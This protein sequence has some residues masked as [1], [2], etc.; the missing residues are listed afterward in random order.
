MKIKWY[1]STLVIILA[2]VGICS[3]QISSPNQEILIKYDIYEVS[4]EQSKKAIDVI[5]QQLSEFGVEDFNVRESE[6]GE[7]RISYRS[8]TAVESIK[9][10]L[11]GKDLG[12]D[13]ISTHPNRSSDKTPTKEPHKNFNLD[14][15]EL[16]KSSDTNSTGKFAWII[17]Q[18]YDRYLNSNFYPAFNFTE[19]LEPSS[20]NSSGNRTFPDVTITIKN[21]HYIIPEV[22]AGPIISFTS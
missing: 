21:A 18:D 15:Y 17:K 1:I 5:K 19:V 14:V 22:R 2:F 3:N 20:F 16:Q 8:F 10:A 9:Q 13:F 6:N 11:S 4:L 7:I 12:F